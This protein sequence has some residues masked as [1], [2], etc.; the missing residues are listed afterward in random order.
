MAI[1]I[2]VKKWGNNKI[3]CKR[4]ERKKEQLRKIHQRCIDWKKWKVNEKKMCAQLWLV[5]R[6]DNLN[7]FAFYRLAGA[8]FND[9]ECQFIVTR[10]WSTRA[11]TI[12]VYIF[13][14]IITWKYKRLSCFCAGT[15][16]KE[17]EAHI[18]SHRYTSSVMQRWPVGG[19]ENEKNSVDP[20]NVCTREFLWRYWSFFV[21][22][23]EISFHD[24]W[25][26]V[27]RSVRECFN[28][29]FSTEL[30]IPCPVMEFVIKNDLNIS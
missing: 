17:V 6:V 29:K 30:F 8:Q 7:N 21:E 3:K 11:H 28:L 26:I 20:K 1:K 5:E 9:G 13:Y 16:Q 23:F 18:S 2:D 22:F 19:N 15:G 10:L 25:E 4:K 24:Y 27:A 12:I 14:Q